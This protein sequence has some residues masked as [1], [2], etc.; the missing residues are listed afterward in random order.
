MNDAKIM[1]ISPNMLKTYE[2]CPAKFYL[3]YVK[4]IAMPVNEDIFEFGKNI[5]AIA[6]YYL[7]NENVDKMEGSL[8]SNESLL[9]NYL[10]NLPYFSYEVVNTEYNLAFKYDDIFLGGRI[11]ALVKKENKY[12]ILDYK[13][14]SVPQ[15]AKYDFQTIIYFLAVHKFFKTSNIAFIYIDLKN[16]SE[17]I[18]DFTDELKT[19][20]LLK[21]KNILTKIY[22]LD[23]FTHNKE[24]NCEY[25]AVCNFT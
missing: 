15:N 16:K 5:H 8:T 18:I 1:Q 14:G 10:K 9:W 19:E 23:S 24:C 22:S 20:Y 25:K 13:T 4:N 2:Q 3:K 6:S 12:Y 7:K 21:L 17:I 11:D